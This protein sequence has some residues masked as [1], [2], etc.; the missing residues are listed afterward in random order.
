MVIGSINMD[1]VVE[2]DRYP[3]TGETVS[4]RRVS[5]L[6]G[7]KGA[8]QAVA[9]ARL[10]ADVS[11]IGAVGDDSF[12]AKLL[13]GLVAEGVD[14]SGV[15]EIH[16][17]ASGVASIHVA[18]DDNSIVVVRGANDALKP[19]LIDAC[20]S[21]QEIDILMLQLEIPIETVLYAA[22]K[23]KTYGKKVL[24][25]LYKRKGRQSCMVRRD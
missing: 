20:H 4:R 22:R 11:L 19:A 16:D 25:N 24:L 14:V 12:G 5:Y 18:N 17:M 9:C 8:N 2:M 15:R 21:F 3:V 10:G 6:P 7:G 13:E 23:A 1:I